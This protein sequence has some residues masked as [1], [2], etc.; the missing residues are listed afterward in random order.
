[1]AVKSLD[2]RAKANA[3]VVEAEGVLLHICDAL[4]AAASKVCYFHFEYVV[5]RLTLILDPSG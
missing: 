5:S 3:I 1:V 2:S 4:E